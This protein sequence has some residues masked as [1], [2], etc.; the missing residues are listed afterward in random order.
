MV[1]NSINFIASVIFISLGW[2]FHAQESSKYDLSIHGAHN[3]P[4]PRFR[5]WIIL[6]CL[7]QFLVLIESIV[8]EV[9]SCRFTKVRNKRLRMKL[10]IR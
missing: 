3:N 2:K 7:G 5:I 1:A 6:N 4:L 9:N 8:F 10:Q